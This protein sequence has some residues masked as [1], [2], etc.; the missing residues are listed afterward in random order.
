MASAESEAAD[1]IE[2]A[3]CAGFSPSRRTEFLGG[4]SCARAAL[5]KLGK[6]KASIRASDEGIPQWPLGTLGSITH[7]KR[8]CGAVVA[9]TSDF[10]CLG[11]D[12][13]QA[14]R[15]SEG[16][17]KHVVHPLEADF[18]ESHPDAPTFL[19]SLKEAFYKAQYPKWHKKV[20]FQD[21]ALAVDLKKEC[22]EVSYI[23]ESV[24]EVAKHPKAQFHFRTTRVDRIIVALCWVPVTT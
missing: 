13:E 18:A 10:Q 20:N 19:F 17:A 23:N 2:D 22:A 24:G 6:P 15:L 11:L 7:T 3:V 21:I 4:R 12:F 8:L 1:A 9:K 5:S 14:G 16:A